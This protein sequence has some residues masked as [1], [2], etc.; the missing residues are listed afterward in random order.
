MPDRFLGFI[1]IAC[2]LILVWS[3]YYTEIKKDKCN[4]LGGAY[5]ETQCVKA[6]L[7]KINKG[8]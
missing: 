6:E 2:I 8:E 5:I 1:V 7:I 3:L 4:S